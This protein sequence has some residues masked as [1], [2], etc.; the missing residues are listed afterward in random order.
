MNVEKRFNLKFMLKFTVYKS[1][2]T[3][4]LDHLTQF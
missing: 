2:S 4:V 3:F 1:N